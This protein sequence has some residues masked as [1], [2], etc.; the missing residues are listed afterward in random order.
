MTETDWL[1]TDAPSK[2]FQFVRTKLPA[3]KLQLLSCACC[4][5]IDRHLT[6]AQRNL[7]GVI[8]RYADGLEHEFVYRRVTDECGGAV[9]TALYHWPADAPD[10][11]DPSSTR[12][13]AVAR[14]LQAVVS[15]P[16]DDG[17]RLTMDWVRAAEARAAGPGMGAAASQRLNRPIC[18]LFREVVG[19][20]F[21]PRT[22]VGPEWVRGG[23][24][25][26][27]WMVRVGETARAV[28]VGIQAERAFDRMPILADALEDDGCS[29]LDLLAHLRE[30]RPH[31]RGC[32][33][34]DLVLGKS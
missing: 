8:E 29:D 24:T 30:N 19:N 18:E 16:A 13:A 33:A 2:L 6:D 7:L 23:G 10:D 20:P 17:L 28:A 11:F 21:Q 14:A 15:T 1:T 27:P 3:R 32:W 31:V 34:L 26:V 4:R 12:E 25:V 9:N 22:V 5:L